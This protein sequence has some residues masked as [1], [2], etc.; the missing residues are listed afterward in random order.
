MTRYR[1]RTDTTHAAIRDA[2][3][4]AGYDVEDYSNVGGGV[5]DLAVRRPAPGYT[6]ERG[7]RCWVEC[8]TLRKRLTE[9]EIRFCHVAPGPFIIALTPEQAID[10]LREL[11]VSLSAFS[12]V[13]AGW[14]FTQDG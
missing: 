4:A 2:L 7:F 3:R 9:A 10:D 13:G 12:R 6:G 11:E 5:W 14:L 8:K 1:A